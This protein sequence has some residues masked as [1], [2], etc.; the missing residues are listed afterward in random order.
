MSVAF[1]VNGGNCD[2]EETTVTYGETYGNLPTPTKTGYTFDGWYTAL[3]GG[4]K[5]TSTTIVTNT[6]SHNLYAHWTV[7]TYTVNFNVNG[8]TCST[9][10]KTV[11]YGE[12]YGTLPT[13]TRSGYTF[14]GWYTEASGGT[15]VVASSTYANTSNQILYAHWKGNSYTI[16][17]DANGGTCDTATK[18]VTCGSTYGTLPTPTREGYTFEGWYASTTG[19]AKISDTT[20]VTISNNQTLYAHWS[21]KQCT[22]AFYVNGGSCDT[23]DMT[24]TYGATYGTLPTATKTGYTFDG[25]YTELDGGTKVTADTKVTTTHNLYAH[26]VANEYTLSFNVNGG[27]CSTTSKAIAYESIYGPLPT[28]TRAGYT[29]SGWYTSATGGTQVTSGTTCNTVGNQVVYAHWTANTYTVTFNANTGKCST[30]SKKVTYG[31]TYGTLPIPTKDNYTFD[32]WYTSASSDGTQVLNTTTCNVA[33]N[34]TLYAHWKANT[35]TITFDANGGT[36]TTKTVEILYGEV[37]GEL[38][39]A[40][41]EGYTFDGWFTSKGGAINVTSTSLTT[42]DTTLYAH[43]TANTYRLNFNPN[44][45]VCDTATKTLS[46]GATYGTLPTPTREGYTF[47]G[48]YTA[49]DGGTKVDSTTT[50]SS[51]SDLTLYAHWTVNTYTVTFNAN[52]GACNVTSIEVN[53]GETF[54]NL[55]IPTMDGHVLEGWYCNGSK[56]TASDIVTGDVTL[57]AQWRINS[58]TVNFNANGG[59]C[60]TAS[61]EV[62]YGETYGELPTATRE[63]YMF[64][65]WYTS[66][67]GDNEVTESS[68]YSIFGN[69]ILYAHWT[70]IPV[71]PTDKTIVFGEDDWSFNNSNLYFGNGEY[72]ISNDYYNALL[73][74]LSNKEKQ[75]VK[76]YKE[77]SWRGSCYGL[78]VLTILAKEG[79]FDVSTIQQDANY[80]HDLSSPNDDDLESLINYY[81]LTQFSEEVQQEYTNNLLFLTEEQKLDRLIQ[82]ASQVK[83]GG[84]PVLLGYTNGSTGHAVVAYGVEYGG[85]NRNGY[86][87]DTRVKICDSNQYGQNEEAYLFYNSIS[88]AWCIPSENAYSTNGGKINFVSNDLDLLNNDGYF[89]NN[90]YKYDESYIAVLRSSATTS[91]CSISRVKQTSNG[92]WTAN[93]SSSDGLVRYFC[94]FYDD[95]D[96]SSNEFKVALQDSQ[97]AWEFKLTN[98][99]TDTIDLD[100][101]YE[102]SLLSADVSNGTSV[103][104]APEGIIEI[105]AV[106]S[107][108]T[109][110]MVYNEGCYTL[111]WYDVSVSGHRAYVTSMTKTDEGIVLY[112]DNLVNVTVSANSD[113]ITTAVNFSTTANTVLIYDIDEYTIGIAVDEDGDGT[114]DTDNPIAQTEHTSDLNYDDQVDAMD[115]LLMKRAILGL[116]KVMGDLN[117]D[118]VTNILDLIALKQEVLNG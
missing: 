111:P 90:S 30:A 49:L 106:D 80:L 64:D 10:S 82:L 73:S 38:P 61:M 16:T 8:G 99:T 51:T 47:N 14:S 84:T 20:K 44:G 86:S 3:S 32:G 118:G 48:W 55:P 96:S 58:Y 97:S 102:D 15:K 68:E 108:Y 52:G 4:T 100:M 34:Q 43:W 69:Q 24:V 77:Q 28:P 1:Y 11:T 2:T 5:V 114:F 71:T 25:W 60:T 22:V 79:I 9:L 76:E 27:T 62:T 12:T 85:W 53:Y 92:D 87:Y 54:G 66:V 7:N 104:F 115:L 89:G 59:F 81:Y 98:G 63:G 110:D 40:T 37:Y 67:D 56:V 107:D 112:G 88:N 17:F 95:E 6:S 117:Q 57:Y 21:V 83:D 46:Y 45:G 105:G 19:T 109:L 75:K 35:N 91:D 70:E 23:E 29:F 36:C 93:N 50:Y 33:S 72:Y 41:R 74:K 103:K 116:S 42:G 39:T 94:D 113:D 65:G 101:S 78:A 26:W 18:S 31:G 13:P